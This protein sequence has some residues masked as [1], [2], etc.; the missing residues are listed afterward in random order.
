[1]VSVSEDHLPG[2][3]V[4]LQD[5]GAHQLVLDL[6]AK[7]LAVN[8]HD[9]RCRD[10]AAAMALAHHALALRGLQ[11][12]GGSVLEACR[13]LE[14]AVRLSRESLRGTEQASAVADLQREALQLLKVGTHAG[15]N[16]LAHV[17]ATVSCG[18]Y[19]QRAVSY[20][21]QSAALTQHQQLRPCMAMPRSIRPDG[22]F[23]LP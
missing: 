12:E 4:L 6:G 1:V 18:C 21:L 19:A 2:A 8:S 14:A 16:G 7:W 3:L 10:T 23:Q 9:I 11:Q 20:L 15:R 22:P 5:S 17:Q 13:H